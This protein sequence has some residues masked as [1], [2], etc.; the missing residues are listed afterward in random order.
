MIQINRGN[1]FKAPRTPIIAGNWKMNKTVEEALALV[2]E[3]LDDLEVYEDVEIVLAPPFVAL[4]PLLDLV[5][6]TSIRLGAQNMYFKESGAFTGEV[7]PLMLREMCDYVIIG[8]SERRAYFHETDE[9]VNQKAKAAIKHDLK[10]IIA[11]GE[12]LEQRESGQTDEW[13]ANQV[14]KALQGISEDDINSVVIAYE[15][16]W[17]IGTGRAATGEM[18]NQVCQLIRNTIAELYSQN[19]ANQIRIQY[20]GSVT[21][22]NIEEFIKQPD[23][24][25][26]LVGGASLKA[27]DFVKIVARTDEFS[28]KK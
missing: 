2:D 21:G 26:A 17:A 18:A 16:I 3:M 23:I 8:H 4:Y 22:D 5:E 12:N 11:V 15:P 10:P 6:D 28:R 25:G 19:I 24:D 9:D 13:V 1:N 20:G 14:R 7:S 27:A